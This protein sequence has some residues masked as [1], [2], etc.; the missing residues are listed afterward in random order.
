MSIRRSTLMTSIA[1]TLA[2]GF[3]HGTAVQAQTT[4]KIGHTDNQ[5]PFDS[6]HAA[7]SVVFKGVLEQATS[8]KIQVNIFPAS[9]LGKERE[10]M[11]AVK[12]GTMEAVI[13]TEGTTVN[14]FAP[15][16][17]L[18]IPFLYPTIDV[19][20]KV[21]DGPFGQDLKETMRKQ[22]GFRVIG[23]A[24][25][26]PFR[27]FGTNKPVQKVADLKGVRIRTMEHPGHQAMVRALGAAPTPLPFGEVYSA[28]K[29]GVIDGLELP[30]QAILN[31]KL[32]EVIS[33]VIA[34]G[35]LFN[36]TF[37]IVSD[38]WFASLPPDHQGAVLNAGAAAEKAGR[39]LVQ[40]WE[41]VGAEELKA[42]G[43]KIHFPTAAEQK[44]FRERAQPPVI[45]MLKKELDPKW[46]DGILR[47]VEAASKG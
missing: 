37:L 32:N 11:E 20:W 29:S 43:V 3:A 8:G 41:A 36:Q 28:L 19:A 5:R 30:Y 4:V 42:K 33:H 47:A 15:M 24:A 35:H 45:E 18:G 21:M 16:G 12:L 44:E 1:A 25:P 46:S 40:I 7:M 27:N 17:V 23:T 38:K 39:G 13:I 10:M 31:M 26:G 9:Q 34:D 2:L 22:T 14:F 6:P